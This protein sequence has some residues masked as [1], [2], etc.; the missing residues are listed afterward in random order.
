MKILVDLS[1]ERQEPIPALLYNGSV[2]CMAMNENDYF[3]PQENADDNDDDDEDEPDLIESNVVNQ[4]NNNNNSNQDND[5]NANIRDEEG[6]QVIEENSDK[7]VVENEEDGE[8]KQNIYFNIKTTIDPRIIERSVKLGLGDFVFYSVLM[9]RAAL[10]DITTV[11]TCFIAIITVI[12][13]FPHIFLIIILM[14]RLSCRV[15]S[16]R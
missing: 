15:S 10:Y 1:H 2:S 12:I 3:M 11:F 7:I 5:H 14:N 9:G 8:R 6:E 16:S 13:I 4:N